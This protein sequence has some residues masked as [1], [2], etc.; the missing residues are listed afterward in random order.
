[1]KKILLIIVFIFIVSILIQ[2]NYLLEN[3][4]N[5]I[6]TE[7]IPLDSNIQNLFS[8]DN[9]NLRDADGS[10]YL[11]LLTSEYTSL[12]STV[13]NYKNTIIVNSLTNLEED[14]NSDIRSHP[15]GR[16][17]KN[18]Y[19]IGSNSN[20]TTPNSTNMVG[21]WYNIAGEYLK[22]IDG[23]VYVYSAII[24]KYNIADIDEVGST[25][26]LEGWVREDL[27]KITDSQPNIETIQSYAEEYNSE[28][29]SSCLHTNGNSKIYNLDNLYN[30]YKDD[31][32]R[33]AV[34]K[35]T[36]KG[37][38]KNGSPNWKNG[39]T[40]GINGELGRRLSRTTGEENGGIEPLFQVD[41]PY[42][43]DKTKIK[44]TAVSEIDI[45]DVD[46]YFGSHNSELANGK[47]E[48]IDPLPLY[49]QSVKSFKTIDLTFP[50]EMTH[51]CAVA[52]RKL[53]KRLNGNT[54]ELYQDK[55]KH[56]CELIVLSEF[57]YTTLVEFKDDVITSSYM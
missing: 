32:G 35:V 50:V 16:S 28:G 53:I 19:I 56:G 41:Q 43:G 5:I 51:D 30:L 7:V 33:T 12:V 48:M 20:E 22:Y 29:S 8:T 23:V 1:M 21:I 10:I 49:N 45:N 17:A 2:Y 11:K 6:V 37:E 40:N 36:Y 31:R 13:N 34:W 3:F 47:N 4:E 54:L 42:C 25:H 44:V 27:R 39:M 14:I 18:V 52:A 9:E 15:S 55:R 46:L 57:I 26:Y 24:Q 38:Y